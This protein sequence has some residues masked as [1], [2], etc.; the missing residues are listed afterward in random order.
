M[1]YGAMEY[2]GGNIEFIILSGALLPWTHFFF[3]FKTS[4][5][6]IT[7]KDFSACPNSLEGNKKLNIN[8]YICISWEKIF[9]CAT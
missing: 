4:S 5:F 6:W 7:M 8:V 2:F 1:E 9:R 3:K